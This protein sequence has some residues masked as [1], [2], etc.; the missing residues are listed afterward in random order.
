MAQ[1]AALGLLLATLTACTNTE[2]ETYPDI[3]GDYAGVGVGIT[4]GI[5]V[6]STFHLTLIQSVDNLYHGHVLPSGDIVLDGQARVTGAECEPTGEV[7]EVVI[8]L[9]REG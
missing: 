4:D 5:N 2:P 1:R 3:A 7:L 8:Y 6:S 9:E